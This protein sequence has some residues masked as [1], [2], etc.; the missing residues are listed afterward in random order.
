MDVGLSHIIFSK[1]MSAVYRGLM[2]VSLD[3][4]AVSQQEGLYVEF[5]AAVF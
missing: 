1:E 5:R 4:K 2:L 3:N